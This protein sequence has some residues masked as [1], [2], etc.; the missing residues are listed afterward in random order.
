MSFKNTKS[1]VTFVAKGWGFEKWAD[2][3]PEYCGKLLYFVKNRKC[4]LHYHKLKT[5][6]FYL[7]SGK[8]MVIW[9][10]DVPK[11]EAMLASNPEW[12]GFDTFCEKT[13]LEQGDTFFVPVGRAHQMIALEDS[14]LFEFSTQHFDQDSYR[15]VKGD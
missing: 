9:C 11:L 15:I 3:R 5:E 13:I 7:H 8:I 14:E 6:T 2:N 12:N 4:S 1:E 10:D